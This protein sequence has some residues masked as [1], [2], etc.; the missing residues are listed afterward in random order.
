MTPAVRDRAPRWGRL[1][2][3]ALG[4]WLLAAP[5]LARAA[6][7]DSSAVPKSVTR[8]DVSP[9]PP[10]PHFVTRRDALFLGG[11]VAGTAIAIFNDRWLTRQAV[12]AE[13]DPTQQRLADFFQPLGN[14]RY[15]L[16]AAALLYGGGRLL[17]HPQFARRSV[18]IG[19]ATLVAGGGAMVL[20]RAFGRERPFESPEQSNSF[21]PFSSH[22]SFPSG[23]AAIAFGAATA[24]DRET[25][26]RWVPWVV[27]P[28]AA[29]VGWSRVHD[30]QHWTSDVVAGAAVGGWLAWKTETFL[31]RRALGV[32]SKGPSG[33]MLF[34]APY[35]GTLAL[36]LIHHFD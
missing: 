22:S 29:L 5:G 27:Y 2:H 34:L 8:A 21:K 23:H 28:A 10:V 9:Q 20:K 7:P 16:P 32:P 6:E 30:D 35:D 26:G 13:A 14:T 1:H 12:K 31:A 17:G 33:D 25:S 19:M 36:T 3:L 4:A 18:R 11:A 15:V 24:V